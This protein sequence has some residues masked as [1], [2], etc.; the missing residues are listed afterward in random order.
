MV[1]VPNWPRLR[2]ESWWLLSSRAFVRAATLPS[3]SAIWPVSRRMSPS[4][5]S[6]R[7]HR[8][9]RSSSF[10]SS[11]ASI[12]AS[13]SRRKAVSSLIERMVESSDSMVCKSLIMYCSDV[14]SPLI[15]YALCTILSLSSFAPSSS[16]ETLSSR[17]LMYLFV[18]ATI[19]ASVSFSCSSGMPVMTTGWMFLNFERFL[20]WR[21]KQL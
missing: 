6:M 14:M 21:S 17:S 4:F 16:S 15:G 8:R 5:A 10:S 9:L 2:D 11:D 3:R 20:T 12:L 19:A 1:L 13:F 7:A 18:C